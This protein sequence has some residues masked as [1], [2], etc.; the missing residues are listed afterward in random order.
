LAGDLGRQAGAAKLLLFHHS[1][2]YSQSPGLLAAE[3]AVAFVGEDESA[4]VGDVQMHSA[5][6]K[7]LC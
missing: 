7:S 6:D 5:F 2:R 4:T 1:P 3:A